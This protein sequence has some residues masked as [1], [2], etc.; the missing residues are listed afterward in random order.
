ME[1]RKPWQLAVILA[2][3]VLTLYNILPTIFY[4]SNPLSDPID[5]KR[6]EAIRTEMLSRVEKLEPEGIAWIESFN[7]LLGIR[8][9]DIA[10]TPQNPGVYT[11]TFAN[12]KDAKKFSK[13]LPRAGSL[14]PFVPAQLS[15]G[16]TE[17]PDPKKVV[18]QRMIDVDVE[19]AHVGRWFQFGWV[20]NKDGSP[21]PFYKEWVYGRVEPILLELFGKSPLQKEV[22]YLLNQKGEEGNESAL[23]VA[24]DLSHLAAALGNKHFIVR[25]TLAS[26]GL[27]SEQFN[28]LNAKFEM[29]DQSLAQREEALKEKPQSEETAQWVNSNENPYVI[30]SDRK[31]LLDAKNIIRFYMANPQTGGEK[32]IGLAQAKKLLSKSAVKQGIE[33]ISLPGRNPL[34]TGVDIDWDNDRIELRLDPRVRE[35]VNSSPQEEMLAL[36]REKVE[37][38]L[39][40]QVAELRRSTGEDVKPTDGNYAIAMSPL[41]GTQS[42]LRMDL[43]DLAQAEAGQLTHFIQSAWKRETPDFIGASYPIRGYDAYQK[44][45]STDKRVGLVVYAP[46]AVTGLPQEGFKE[47]SIYVIAKGIRKMMEQYKEQGGA[48]KKWLADFEALRELLAHKGFIGYPGSLYGIDSAYKDDFIFEWNDFYSMLLKATR[49]N[50][51][52]LGNQKFALLPFS[53]VEQRILTENRIGDEKQEALLQWREDYHLA[54]VD[55]N[56]VQ[57]YAV[58]APTKNAFWENLKLSADKYFRGDDRKIIKLG[59]DLSGGKAVRIGLVD[60]AG[61]PVT[62][63]DDLKQAVQELYTRVNKLGVS[64]RTI[65]IQN[66]NIVLEFPGSKNLSAQELVKASSMTFHIVNEK[67]GVYNPALKEAVHHFLQEVWNEAVVKNQTDIDSLNEIAYNHLGGDQGEETPLYPRSEYAKLLYNEG[68]R[69]AVPGNKN[70]SNQF[71]DAISAVARYRGEDFNDWMGQTHPLV[72]VFNNYALEGSSLTNVQP[73]YDPNKGNLLTFE[74]KRSYEGH[75]NA[76][77]QDDLYAWTSIFSEESIQ[78]TPLEVYSGGHGWR[79][80]VIYNDEII[81]APNLQGALK[82]RASITGRFT[83]REISTLAAELKAGSLSFTP[84]ILSEY[85]I[86]PDLGKEERINGVTAAIV[87][88]VLVVVAMCF[89]YRFFGLIASAAVL[90][91]L[92]IMWGVYQNIEAALTLPAIAGIV[93]TIGM[94]VDANVLVYER[95]KEEYAVSGRLAGAIYAGYRKAFSAIFDSNITTIIAAL[96][97]IQFDSGPIKGFAVTLIIGIVSSMFTSLFMTRYFFSFW[98]ERTKEKSLKMRQW[99]GRTRI[100]FLSKSTLAIIVSAALLVMGCGLFIKDRSTIFGMDFTGGYSLTVESVEN[101]RIASPRILA[102]NSLIKAGVAPVDVQVRELSRPNQ[103]QIHLGMGVENEGGVFHG[104]PQFTEVPAAKYPY[105]TMPRLNWVVTTLQKAGLQFPEKELSSVNNNWSVMSGQFSDAMRTNAVLALSL[106]LVAILIY[107]TFR[108]EFNYALSAVIGL[109]HDVLITLSFLC[110]FHFLGFPVQI[111]LIVIG[112][113]LT[114]IGYSLNDTIIV[115]DRIREDIKTMKKESLIDVVNHS[116]NVTLSRTVMT[117]GTTLLVLLSLLFLGGPSIF[118]FSLVMTLGVFF[119]TFSSLFVAPYVF[120]KLEERSSEKKR[121]KNLNLANT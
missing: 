60:H 47:N 46:S 76:N 25:E 3:L 120:L 35:I 63:P 18:V 23:K 22:A 32:P 86:S 113:I 56:P 98:V 15:L 115:F 20:K 108:F 17:N 93:L 11:V 103:I 51:V 26:L 97:L 84:K 31:A 55:M 14:I 111:D 40:A 4:Y 85:N 33:S 77:P 91:N 105:Q 2:V 79:M 59:L 29:I 13:Y 64:E 83:Q 58:P 96:I 100:N 101:P 87:A 95:M 38:M 114:I 28:S 30:A 89:Y 71:N 8:A 75:K 7:N 48:Q 119:G 121:G 92:L 50:F 69:F 24:K 10:Y 42:F 112:A 52:T 72:I 81:S 37:Q 68:L 80:A 70:V 65:R 110:L 1:K 54:Q 9:K 82:D 36:E 90:L 78:G 49:E 62:Q 34:F 109:V 99:F 67:F 57:H 102:R 5:E 116:L 107:I 53:D 45:S 74:I 73:G 21:T 118:A 88:C 39:F 117:S 16:A 43:S 27:T 66:D 61:R 44:E 106:A 19:K 12:D 104:M 94:A 41:P 6:A